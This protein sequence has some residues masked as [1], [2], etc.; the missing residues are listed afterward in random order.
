M[1]RQ[2]LNKT[3]SFLR[4]KFIVRI[5][6]FFFV[7]PTLV[8]GSLYHLEQA[9]MFNVEKNE[10]RLEDSYDELVILRPHLVNMEDR[11]KN[12]NGRSLWEI[13]LK[14][15]KS[16]LVEEKWISHIGI[17]RTWPRTLTVQIRPLEVKMIWVSSRGELF[18]VL[19][20]G[21]LLPKV[22][23]NQSPDAPLLMGENFKT[24]PELRMKV[25]DFLKELPRSGPFAERQISEIRFSEK[26]GFLVSLVENGL[27][28]K[29]GENNLALK[30][31]RVSQ[32][33]DYM[34]LHQFEGRVI[35]AN[36]SKKVLVKLRKA[37]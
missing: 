36:F 6:I 32:V 4:N 2:L 17:A 13:R 30:S 11:L 33:L 15:V 26:E 22:A 1:K 35:D 37:P 14:D 16:D 23:S 24:N 8:A 31:A 21:E 9:G 27:Q 29:M 12:Q 28:V 34:A 10:V 7:L 3:E 5:F 20:N 25:L 18:P 19:E